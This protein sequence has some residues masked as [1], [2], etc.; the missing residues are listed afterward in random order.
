MNPIL[1]HLL[2]LWAVVVAVVGTIYLLIRRGAKFK[3]LE[4]AGIFGFVGAA[5]GVVIGLTTFFASSHYS[6]FRQ[7]AQTEATDVSQVSA[8]SGS[9]PVRDGVLLRRQ[10][11]C[12]ATDVIDDEWTRTDGEGAPSVDARQ[13]AGY[14]ILLHVGQGEPNPPSW[15]SNA[16]GAALD[17]GV[18]RQDRLL[19]A[20]PHIPTLL[21]ILIYVGAA[22]IVVYSFFF[23]A[24]SRKQFL[25]MLAAVVLMLS[26]VVGVLA[27]LDTPTQSV[28]GLDPTAMELQRDVIEPDVNPKGVDPTE[29]CANV[30]SP[31]LRTLPATPG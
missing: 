17:A 9:F 18:E 1:L 13:Q 8:L 7:A 16:M 12:Y 25:W 15:Y 14:F 26:A 2:I 11:Y 28:F 5:F 10:L 20:E 19:L 24:S 4:Y 30:P 23:H 6:D 29:F 27:G 22:L 21:W 3:A 31:R